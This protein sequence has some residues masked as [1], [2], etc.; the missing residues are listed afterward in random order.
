MKE[1]IDKFVDLPVAQRVA[2]GFALFAVLCAS[3]YY[4][5]LQGLEESIY[6]AN[7]EVTVLDQEITQRTIKV[8]RLPEFKAEVKR[9][10]AELSIALRELPDRK[11]IE[12]LLDQV[13]SKA[14]E[15]GLDVLLF[16][17]E[18]EQKKDFYA[19]VP[20]SLEVQGDFYQLASFFDE[21]AH[22][23]RIVNLT[24][25][26]IATDTKLKDF[27]QLRT[28]LVATTFRFLDAAERPKEEDLKAKKRRKKS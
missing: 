12:L 10:D 3:F 26:K 19:E 7:E 14:K 4:F 21:V 8:K 25:F 28:N 23:E 1:Y 22:L 9:L 16:K 17:P 15:A 24:K 20:V 27:Q 6:Q 5:I 11:G 13:S 2:S 18:E